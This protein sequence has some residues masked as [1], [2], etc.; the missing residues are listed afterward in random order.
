MS[1][2]SFNPEGDDWSAGAQDLPQGGNDSGFEDSVP[3][4]DLDMDGIDP[5]AFGGGEFVDREGKYH[6]EIS[7]APFKTAAQSFRKTSPELQ[8]RMV[9]LQSVQG[10]SPAGSV[11][12]HHLEFPTADDHNKLVGKTQTPLFGIKL[13]GLC[14]LGVACGVFLKKDGKVIDPE[15]GGTKINTKT[16]GDRLKG[17]Q[18]VVNVKGRLWLEG[19]GSPRID[20]KTGKQ[21]VSFEPAQY[22]AFSAVDDP[23]NYGVPMNGA[24]LAAI[25]KKQATAPAATGNGTAGNGGKPKQS[26]P[27]NGNG[28][29]QQ[30]APAT[31]TQSTASVTT[32]IPASDEEFDI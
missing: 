31:A 1:S 27:A 32:P 9:V 25:G 17:K 18:V 12:F 8:V 11:L 5:D 4:I 13:R 6:C 24:A 20:Q 22:G 30:A 21:G 14:E 29:Q 28:H 23:A 19:D 3:D 16:L 7:G 15:T 26:A 2:D 10:Q